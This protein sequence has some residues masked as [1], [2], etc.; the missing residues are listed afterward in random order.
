LIVQKAVLEQQLAKVEKGEASPIEPLKNLILE[1]NQAPK[2]V[3]GNNRLEMKSFLK[4]NRIEPPNPHTDA[5][6]FIQKKLVFIG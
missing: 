4:K 6:R 5:N 1:A 3:L 2:W